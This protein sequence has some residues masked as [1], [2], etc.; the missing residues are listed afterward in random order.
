MRQYV[1][2]ILPILVFFVLLFVYTKIAGPIPF[3]I[4]SV[5]TTKSDT[6]N[7]TGE[8][9]VAIKPDI[10]LL[11]VGI[12]TQDTTVKAAQEQINSVSTKVAE[13]IKKL[14]IDQKDIKTSNYNINPDYD[15]RS[16]TQKITGYTASTN[17]TIKV[18]D[19]DKVNEVIDVSTAN[20]ANQVGS[21]SFDVD[22]RSKAENEAREKAVLEAKKKA[23]SAAKIAGFRLGK[24]VNYSEN[25]GGGIIQPLRMAVG[26]PEIDTK[27]QTAVE[28]G[29]SEIKVIVTLSYEIF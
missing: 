17:L 21:I 29:S 28:P 24:M 6:F 20:G 14:G 15:F 10:A 27:T 9:T 18:R 12:S 23:E 11:N 25:F 16:G 19:I 13:A 8:G 22:D 4:N 5:T 1:Q 2:I 3:S 7:V 26:S